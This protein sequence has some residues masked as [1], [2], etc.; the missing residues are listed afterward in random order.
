MYLERDDY[1]LS[2]GRGMICCECSS[3]LVGV[4]GRDWVS[5]NEFG[6]G[7]FLAVEKSE[8]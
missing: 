5:R 1:V 7:C 2:E 3:F 6:R 4:S 8:N